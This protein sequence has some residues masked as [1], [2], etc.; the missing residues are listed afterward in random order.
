MSK[1]FCIVIAIS[2]GSAIPAFATCDFA[3]YD[4]RDALLD[5]QSVRHI[6]V[7]IRNSRKWAMNGISILTSNTSI[8]EAD[9][10]KRMRAEVE[11]EY[12]F[13]TCRYP[14][15]VRQNGDWKDHIRYEDGQILASIDVRLESGNILGA[16]RFKLL[17]PE[18][19]NGANEV[20]ASYL[21]RRLGYIA[22]ETFVVSADLNGASSEFLFQ[23]NAAKELLERNLRREGPIFEGDES[24][25]WNYE[26]FGLFELEHISLARL[27]NGS[28][29]EKG[30][31]STVIARNAFLRLQAAYL[32][33]T[34]DLNRGKNEF[35]YRL[36]PNPDSDD[37]GFETYAVLLYAMGG[38]HAL[39]PH[40]RKFYFNSFERRFEPIYYDGNV[41]FSGEIEIQNADLEFFLSYADIEKLRE[42]SLEIDEFQM[43]PDFSDGLFV[44]LGQENG[45][46]EGNFNDRLSTVTENLGSL[47][48]HRATL[49]SVEAA[50]T[51]NDFADGRAIYL[52]RT[53]EAGLE[54]DFLELQSTNADS[55]ISGHHVGNPE[56]GDVMTLT[57]LEL[58]EV[59]AD[60]ELNGRRTI[61]LPNDAPKDVGFERLDFLDGDILFSP[62]MGVEIDAQAR[63]LRF[64]QGL[65]DDWALVRSAVL[66]D[67]K[68]NFEG[69]EQ[70]TSLVSSQRFNEFGLTG[71]LNFYDVRFVDTAID[72][73]RGQCEDS[74]NLVS[75]EGSLSELF[76]T[77]SFADAVDIDFSNISID[78]LNILQAGN[79]CFDV[80]TG[81]FWVDTARLTKCGDKGMSV[82]ENSVLEA[83]DV[84]IE[85]ANIG[86]S[87]KDFS[88]VKISS[89]VGSQVATC[90][91]AFR[92]KQEFGG[93]LLLVAE[94][95][96]NG[97]VISDEE[98]AI[99]IND[100]IQ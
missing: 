76:V 93:G 84:S 89:L 45:S 96:C 91:E 40:N 63:V 53:R 78:Q 100:K 6:S 55:S 27:T 11:V 94:F 19:R 38:T 68:V 32:D 46:L 98:S 95:D 21:L 37:S 16:V 57:A 31:V 79:D 42:I 67:W 52:A 75:S 7:E 49:T 70:N 80:S 74:V 73:Q 99:I 8:I 34:I 77:D 36:I 18:T 50:K 4:Y 85:S 3:T 82:G 20:L 25:V 26:D 39:R 43:D 64:T 48:A 56:T 86:V 65:S 41:S 59:M 33:Y 12:E 51:S 92:K 23:E 88:R 61:L 1:A 83:R 14:A 97:A 15:R 71:C 44:R 28:W 10:K 72:G 69:L 60:N 54:S 22:P 29:A 9:Q 30:D 35:G 87:S 62:G 90:M 66:V 13:G 2:I 24:L 5:P 17:L 58:I 81:V 47:I